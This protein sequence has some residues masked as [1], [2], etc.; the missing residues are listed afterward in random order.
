MY[1]GFGCNDEP[2]AEDRLQLKAYTKGLTS[3]IEKCP[4]PM[5]AAI[6]GDWGSGKT[7]ALYAIKKELE[8]KEYLVVNFNTWQYSQFNLGD[9]L[10]FSLLTEI[11]QKINAKVSSLESSQNN[12]FSEKAKKIKQIGKKVISFL[13]PLAKSAATFVGAGAVVQFADAAAEGLRQASESPDFAEDGQPSV[14][15]ALSELRDALQEL[16]ST[17]TSEVDGEKPLTKRLFIFI[18][19]LD[20]LSR[21]GRS[22]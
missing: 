2:T 16:V 17:V 12:D 5:T 4:T 19:D 6:Q 21:C 13:T 3:Y 22:K 14:I 8:D 1:E 11:L 15:E 18:D 20:R 10:I 7:S 9:Q